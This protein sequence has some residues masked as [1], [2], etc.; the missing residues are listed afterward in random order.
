MS[1][2]YVTSPGQLCRMITTSMKPSPL[3][4][5]ESSVAMPPVSVASDSAGLAYDGSIPSCGGW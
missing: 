2:V 5:A 4:S 3:K 1:G